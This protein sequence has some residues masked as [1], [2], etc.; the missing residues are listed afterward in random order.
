MWFRYPERKAVWVLKNFS[1]KLKPNEST[2]LVGQSGC[3]KSTIIQLIY[4]FYDPQEGHITIDGVDIK[5]YNIASLRAMFGLVS[6]EPLLFDFSIAENIR[7]GVPDAPDFE[8]QNAAKNSNAIE[9]IE[10][11]GEEE[12]EG[13]ADNNKEPINT[14]ARII[15]EQNK[16]TLPKGYYVECGLRGGKLSGGQKQR[17]AIARAIIRKPK[18]LMLDEATSALDEESQHIVQEALDRVMKDR[19][20]IVIAHRFVP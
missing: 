9:F 3:G 7:Y 6:Q 11:M 1:L 14:E 15:P 2:A 4:R 17:I 10:R 8:I 13:K 19:T 16:R 12:E 20:S 18:V 5:K